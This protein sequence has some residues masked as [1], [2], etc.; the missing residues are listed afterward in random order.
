MELRIYTNTGI[1]EVKKQFSRFFPF[2]K[3][4]FYVYGSNF[5][6]NEVTSEEPY[7]GL[8]IAE[9]S[10]YFKEGVLDFSPVTT[11]ADLEWEFQNKLGLAIKIFRRAGDFWTDTTGTKNLTLG[12]QNNMG[13]SLFRPV[14]INVNTLFL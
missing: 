10:D 3:L 13:A 5:T 14:K 2:L 12:K 6:K 8:Y 4:E 9:T 11:V 7:Y 1:R